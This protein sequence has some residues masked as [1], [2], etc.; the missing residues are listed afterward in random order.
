VGY[1]SHFV[2]CQKMLGEDEIVRRD[3]VMV[4]Q[5]GLF[6]PKFGATFSN[7]FTQSPQNIAVERGILSFACCID[8]ST[9]SE[10]FGY[11]FVYFNICVI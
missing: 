3:V 7:V 2:F 8:D 1:D 6:S 5:S 9:S 4:K 10:Y 11:Y